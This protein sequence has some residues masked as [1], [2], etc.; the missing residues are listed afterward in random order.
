MEMVFNNEF[1]EMSL[2]E[3]Q[4]VDGGWD[5]DITLGGAALFVACLSVA[6]GTGGIGFCSIP[7]ILGAGTSAEIAVAGATVV[8]AAVS[9]SAVAYGATH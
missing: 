8:G 4:T 6:V 1:C 7:L 3:M 5:W 9:G 2:D